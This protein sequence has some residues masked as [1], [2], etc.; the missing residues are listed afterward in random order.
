MTERI[1][2]LMDEL[3]ADGYKKGVSWKGYDVYV[4]IYD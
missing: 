3:N 4:P 1:E 2:E